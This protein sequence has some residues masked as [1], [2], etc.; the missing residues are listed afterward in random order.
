[1][2]THN[3]EIPYEFLCPIT[4]DIMTNPCIAEDGHSYQIEALIEWLKRSRR[5]PITNLDMGPT[6]IKN[7]Q[8]EQLI[9]K[10]IE[11]RAAPKDL[12]CYN[13]IKTF[14]TLRKCDNCRL[15]FYCSKKCQK[16][17]WH[18]SHKHECL[19]LSN[20]TKELNE[21]CKKCSHFNIFV[22]NNDFNDISFTCL[23]CNLEEQN[24]GILCDLYLYNRC[25]KDQMECHHKNIELEVHQITKKMGIKYKTY[26]KEY[27]CTDCNYKNID[28]GP[29]VDIYKQS[30]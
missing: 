17:H 24:D 7:I 14:S 12:I 4:K 3:I 1:M 2:S 5:S 25:L 16:Q 18:T 28:K 30:I 20:K 27:T 19:E 29:L 15:R 9:T 10:W 23:N 22:T 21:K 26:I 11:E 8:L 6:I 13:C